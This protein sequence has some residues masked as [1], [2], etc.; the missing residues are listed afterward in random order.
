M[1]TY[2]IIFIKLLFNSIST[3]NQSINQSIQAK[4]ALAFKVATRRL[5]LLL[6]PS[7]KGK[8]LQQHKS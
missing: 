8:I 1:K 4:K 7:R 3:L 5:Y 2:L 6:I